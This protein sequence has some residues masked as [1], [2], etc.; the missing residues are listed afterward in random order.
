[1]GL[2]FRIG[3]R[4]SEAQWSYSGFN[5]FRS[6]IATIVGIDLKDMDGF[7]GCKEW[8]SVKDDIALFLNHSDCEGSLTPKQ[9]KKVYPRLSELVEQFPE[10]SIWLDHDKRCGKILVKDMKECVEKNI[11]LEFC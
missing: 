8:N 2:D 6:K 3:K 5:T 1:M 11:N 10:E 9:C 7:G 4:S